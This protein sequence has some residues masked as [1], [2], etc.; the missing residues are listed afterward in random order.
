MG[1]IK[2][3]QVYSIEMI[4]ALFIA[5]LLIITLNQLKQ[6]EYKNYEGEKTYL[7]EQITSTYIQS[8]I[9]RNAFYKAIENSNYTQIKNELEKINGC[10]SIEIFN[11]TINS[12]NQIYSY[13]KN[14][15]TNLGFIQKTFALVDQNNN[16]YFIRLKIED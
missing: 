7:L 5:V 16:F 3:A 11:N 13:S 14:C 2:T 12:N 1:K 6:Q 15:T 4:Y 9:K 10:Y 8:L